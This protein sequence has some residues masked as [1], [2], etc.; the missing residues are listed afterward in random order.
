MMPLS[1]T[2]YLRRNFG[3][4]VSDNRGK[5]ETVRTPKDPDRS[6]GSGTVNLRALWSSE[7]IRGGSPCPSFTTNPVIQANVSVKPSRYK[8]GLRSPRV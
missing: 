4:S 3:F 2:K 1:L 8:M 6:L 5:N 7:G